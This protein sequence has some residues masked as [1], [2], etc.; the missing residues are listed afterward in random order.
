MDQQ[1]WKRA[2]KSSKIIQLS[3]FWTSL[4]VSD[5]VS[6][7]QELFPKNRSKPENKK[8]WTIKRIAKKIKSDPNLASLNTA[9][10][11]I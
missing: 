5:D 9:K 1:N 2:F 4:H 6:V 8:Y 11:S 3:G 10:D 7:D